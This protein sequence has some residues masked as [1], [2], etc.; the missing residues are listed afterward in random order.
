V[1]VRRSSIFRV[2][3]CGYAIVL[4]LPSIQ[5]YFLASSNSSAI[6]DRV[7]VE[8]FVF[9]G[10]F[11]SIFASLTLALPYFID[12]Y[13]LSHFDVGGVNLILIFTQIVV[14]SWFFAN[15]TNLETFLLKS[16]LILPTCLMIFGSSN[17]EMYS[18]FALTI[19]MVN[20]NAKSSHFAEVRY[21]WPVYT[22]AVFFRP[23]YLVLAA[24]LKLNRPVFC[25]IL[26]ACFFLS[27][28]YISALSPMLDNMLNRRSL[29]QSFEANSAIMQTYVVTD[30]SSFF[31]NLGE[32]VLN[33][34]LPVFHELSAKNFLLQV[35]VLCILLIAFVS[36]SNL[37]RSIF[38]LW[39]VFILID[40]DL[41]TF[42]R[43]I[44]ALFPLLYRVR[45]K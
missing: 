45:I 44:G 21:L 13:I 30:F 5:S 40:P 9:T 33:T 18:V 17:K 31:L 23:Y 7:A 6:L 36:H 16:F 39:L 15:C 11:V 26:V 38:S 42:F 43:H 19:F 1:K 28:I 14:V 4:S 8:S 35:Y 22:Y 37:V 29:P 10:N 32:S 2:L 12:L 3:A 27:A 20:I 41:G 25:V 24:G 34:C